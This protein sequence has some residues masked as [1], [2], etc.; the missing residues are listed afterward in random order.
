MLRASSDQTSLELEGLTIADDVTIETPINE[1]DFSVDTLANGSAIVQLQL[2]ESDQNIDNIIKT[3]IDDESFIFNSKIIRYDEAT[4]GNF[5]S[6]LNNLTYNIYYYEDSSD[7]QPDLTGIT[8]SK[9]S[10]VEESIE[11]AGFDYDEIKSF[12]DGSAYLIDKDGDGDIEL[13][14]TFLLDQGFFDTDR[15]EGLIR[16][17][18]ILI[19]SPVPD[20]P[21]VNGSSLVNDATPNFSGTTDNAGNIITVYAENGET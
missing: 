8:L 17:P 16:D 7:S 11:N 2:E 5:E 10:S 19:D 21:T 1:L 3:N 15:S 13:V 6:W 20:A 9:N 12:I 4:D 14:S 18:I